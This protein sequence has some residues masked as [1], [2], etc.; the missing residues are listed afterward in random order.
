V[1][2]PGQIDD[3]REKVAAMLPK[4]PELKAVLCGWDEP[5][6]GALQAIEQAGRDDVWVTGSD[7][8]LDTLE[9]MRKNPGFAATNGADCELMSRAAVGA[10]NELF[11][12]A[13]RETLGPVTNVPSVLITDANLPPKGEYATSEIVPVYVP[14][15]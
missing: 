14:A 6:Q 3:A 11:N 15:S 7:G 4:Y 5:A 12:G 8:N 1:R 2:V 10:L 13:T 9:L